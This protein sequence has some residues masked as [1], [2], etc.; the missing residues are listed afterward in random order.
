[1][2]R[3]PAY[4][5]LDFSATLKNKPGKKTESQWVFNI[6]NAYNRLNA[7]SINFRERATDANGNETATGISEA[8][9]LSYFGIVPGIT[10]EI[11]F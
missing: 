9:K 6:Y 4:H 10:Y 3:L 2:D 8:V 11:K 7:A 5:R 1:G